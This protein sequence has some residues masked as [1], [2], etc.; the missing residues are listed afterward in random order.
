MKEI[1]A[2]LLIAALVLP[3]SGLVV[4]AQPSDTAP[5]PLG[6]EDVKPL[7]SLTPSA[8][9]DIAVTDITVDP[10]APAAGQTV[11]ISATIYNAGTERVRPV[12]V[13]FFVDNTL[14]GEVTING[15]MQPGASK[16]ASIEWVP[17]AEITY[18]V[19]V[20]ATP[21]GVTD[22]N[23][24]NNTFEATVTVGGVAAPT[25]GYN[26]SSFG[27][28]ATEDGSNPATQTLSIWNSGGGTL[29]W[30]VSND[31]AWL[32]L[33]STSGSSTG[34]TDEVTASV[35]ISGMSDGSYSAT[36]TIS[37]LEATNTPQIVPVNL[38]ISAAGVNKWAVVIG[39]A[40][41]RGRLNDLWHP[42]EDAI[43]MREALITKYGFPEENIQMLLNKEATA[44]AIV[45]AIRWLALNE[46]AEST[47][48][49]FFCG[50]GTRALDS[51][52]WDDDVEADGYDESIVTTDMYVLPD[53]LSTTYV[54]LG[55]E[56]ANFES[57]KFALVFG[58][59]Y[60]GGMFDDDDDLQAS[61][62]VIC[63]ACKADQYG[64]DYLELGNTL[65]GYYFVD[66]AVLQGLA[67]GLN[68]SGDGVSMEEA[69]DYA[70]PR[71]T[72]QEPES[73]PQIYDGF[74]GELV[75]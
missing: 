21:V 10:S 6:P 35:D 7:R 3:L 16:V 48:V 8:G 67:E 38:T 20:V 45:D 50:H 30:E 72:A 15:A 60:S 37:A 34:E 24:A 65:F 41:Y 58:S 71:V 57:Q 39:I 17:A 47:V 43:E 11:I 2:V 40:D 1:L 73:E 5:A 18:T 9:V 52:G 23:P 19:T 14:E 31:A 29:N 12:L 27:F 26:P 68:V 70:Y 63:S 53:G 13:E 74:A 42:D 59:C 75:P 44:Q 61:G 22:E 33:S 4:A 46:D 32:S 28:T 51:K 66:E 54:T 36:I 62:R 55:N 49:F 69:L 56:F 25:I 64:W